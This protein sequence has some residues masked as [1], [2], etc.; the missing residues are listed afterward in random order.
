MRHIITRVT[1]DN[2]NNEIEDDSAVTIQVTWP[3]DRAR[4]FTGEADLC[5]EC[6]FVIDDAVRL[7]R[8]TASTAK[9]QGDRNQ[10]EVACPECGIRF[11]ERGMQVHLSRK[12]GIL[13]ET[14]DAK[15]SRDLKVRS[16]H[17]DQLIPCPVCGSKTGV[18]CFGV[19]PNTS[20]FGQ[21]LDLP[22][23]SRGYIGGVE[24]LTLG[25]MAEKPG[26]SFIAVSASQV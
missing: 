16:N 1:C 5:T 4:N 24:P 10:D 8:S 12:H 14:P 17:L 23:R 6:S 19:M 18:K 21:P 11:G 20:T 26:N 9:N 7:F 15:A 2:C 13:S 3:K 25:D 22:H